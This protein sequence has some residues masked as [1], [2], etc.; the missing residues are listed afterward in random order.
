MNNCTRIALYNPIQT[1]STSSDFANIL[2][3]VSYTIAEESL[4]ILE[5]ANNNVQRHILFLYSDNCTNFHQ[6]LR[7]V[8]F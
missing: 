5:W 2:Y 3:R 8:M 7:Q 4:K 1:Y 6:H